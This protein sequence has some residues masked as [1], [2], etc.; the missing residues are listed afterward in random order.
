MD[1]IARPIGEAVVGFGAGELGGAL[2]GKAV[3]WA[4]GKVAGKVASRAE[5]SEYVYTKLQ[6]SIF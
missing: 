2:L 5:I 3:G 4:V 6:Q 1:A